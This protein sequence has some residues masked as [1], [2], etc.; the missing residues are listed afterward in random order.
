M[1]F[2]IEKK[3]KTKKMHKCYLCAKFISIGKPAM[4]MVGNYSGDF[5]SYYMDLVCYEIA[6]LLYDPDND[7]FEYG[8]LDD[9]MRDFSLSCTDKIEYLKLLKKECINLR[10]L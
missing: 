10:K 1:N 8:S 4:K 2:H 5:Y 3:V 7:Y 6:S 9:L